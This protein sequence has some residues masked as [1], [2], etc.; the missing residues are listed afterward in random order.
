[1][2]DFACVS[3]TTPTWSNDPRWC[4][5]GIAATEAEHAKLAADL[6]SSAPV[7]G[8]HR[9]YPFM[10]EDRG[11]LGKSALTVVYIFAVLLAPLSHAPGSSS[12]GQPG[13]GGG[14]QLPPGVPSPPPR[15][16]SS[17]G[18]PPSVPDPAPIPTDHCA[19]GYLELRREAV[20]SYFPDALAADDFLAR[21]EVALYGHGFAPENTI[22]VLNLC[23]D[24]ICNT[25]K[26][27]VELLFGQPFNVHGLGGVLTCG[28]TGMGAGLSHCPR[29]GA[30][31]R[32]KYVFFSFPHIAVDAAGHVG[33]VSRAGRPG[34][35]ACGA[36][37]KVLGE[38]RAR[39]DG[40]N[41]KQDEAHDSDDPEYSI[42]KHRLERHI[43]ACGIPVSQLDLDTLTL[44]AEEAIT[45]DLEALIAESVDPARADYAVVTGVQIHNWALDFTDEEPNLEFVQPRSAYVVVGGERVELNIGAVPE[46]TPR[47]LASTM[48]ASAG[49][50]VT[51]ASMRA[52]AAGAD[53]VGGVKSKAAVAADAATEAMYHRFVCPPA[54]SAEEAYL[55][56]RQR[57]VQR[58]FP[59]AEG[60]DDFL[61]RAEV[62]LHGHGFAPDSTIAV[63]NLCRDE[64]CNTLKSKVQ[65]V[66]GAPF[67]VH[68]LGGVL[69]C[70]VTGMGA[71]LSHCP[72]AAPG[73]REKYVFFS[74]PHIAV[75]AAG[76]V[77]EVSRAGCPGSH[78]CGALL[79]VLGELR[80]EATGEPPVCRIEGINAAIEEEAHDVRDP[81]YSILKH[82]LERHLVEAGIP[83][84]KLSLQTLTLLAEEAITQ[85][86]EAL[87]AASVDPAKADY[88]VVT[89]VQIHNWARD[90][91][92]EEPNLEFVQPCAA[93]AVVDGRRVEL[94]LAGSPALTP[95]MFQSLLRNPRGPADCKLPPSRTRGF[96]PPVP[97]DPRSKDNEMRRR[98]AEERYAAWAPAAEPDLAVSSYFEQR[99]ALLSRTFPDALALE[100]FMGRVEL[101][102]DERGFRPDASIAV[103][104][105]CR[106]E[107]CNTLKAKVQTVYGAPFNVHGLGGVLTCGVTGMGAGLSHC[108]RAAPG[109]REKYVFFSFPHIAVDAAGRVGEVS[110]AGCPGSHACGALL[111]VLG[112]L[113]AEATSDKLISSRIEEFHDVRDPEYSI[114]KHR[115]KRHIVKAGIDFAHLRL[116]TLTVLAEE[117]ITQDL[118]ALIAAT[119]DPAK[120]DYAVVT[121]VQ[122]HNWADEFEGEEPHL[123]YVQPGLLYT[124][125]DGQR[126]DLDLHSITALT[127]R[128]I[129]GLA[130]PAAAAAAISTETRSRIPGWA[131]DCAADPRSKAKMTER[132]ERQLM[133]Q[134]YTQ[135]ND[136]QAMRGYFKLRESALHAPFP[137]ALGAD[138]F[139][140]RVEVE[141]C[142]FGFNAANSIAVLNLCRDEIC[143]PLKAKVQAVYGSPFN[144]HGLGGVL[145]CGVTGMGAGLS[146][147][148]RPRAGGRDKYIFFSFPHIA[149]DAA[150]RVGEVSRAGRPGS[151]A[152][153][154][155]LK[156]L[157]E[158]KR[159]SGEGLHIDAVDARDPEYSILKNRLERHVAAVGV[160]CEEL[161]LERLTALAEEAITQDLEA[162]I[163]ATVDPAKADYAVVTGVQIHNW[164]GEFANEEPNLEFVQPRSV[165]VV[166]GGKRQALDLTKVTALTPRMLKS[167]LGTGREATSNRD[168]HAATRPSCVAPPAAAFQAWLAASQE[169]A[170]DKLA[171]AEAL[172]AWRGAVESP[173]AR[174]RARAPA[175]ASVEP[176]SPPPAAP[177]S[178]GGRE[179]DV[180]SIA[181][182]VAE[183]WPAAAPEVKIGEAEAINAKEVAEDEA[184]EEEEEVGEAQVDG[185]APLDSAPP[186]VSTAD[187]PSADITSSDALTTS[188]AAAEVAPGAVA[189]EESGAQTN[190]ANAGD[191]RAPAGTTLL[192]DATARAKALLASEAAKATAAAADKAAEKAV[193]TAAQE[194][195]RAAVE[196]AERLEAAAAAAAETAAAAARQKAMEEAE[197]ARLAAQQAAQLVAEEAA[198]TAAQEA[199]AEA[200]A[201]RVAA[202]RR[203]AKAEEEAAR[204]AAEKRAAEEAAGQK[205][206]GRGGS[207][208][209][210]R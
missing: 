153:G 126:T 208:K 98:Q 74:F 2:I 120:A 45:K 131:D 40:K 1:M 146:H 163:A 134:R 122:V 20:R 119:V 15:N 147:C 162:L 177:S 64:I 79:K 65:A 123:E 68:G 148:P 97:G 32:D 129:H 73:Q 149:V 19:A 165:Y 199:A 189:P 142:R 204:L 164:A 92:D 152:C 170:G 4:T 128:M 184:K 175:P 10:V 197:T 209:E 62:A 157:G 118:E 77:G 83:G 182:V 156:V 136:S 150:G 210:G 191:E 58:C 166:V 13:D 85:D 112:E 71:G 190:A 5:P 106:D 176:A 49:A 43:A 84:S 188:E 12:E 169:A 110:R 7:H 173:C 193:R 37:L 192:A 107:I 94:D 96:V 8:V 100:D 24:E 90:Y 196:E 53:A 93:Y 23:R 50:A 54:G 161:T 155:L 145:T 135:S 140:A 104:N 80:T 81:E 35:H 187:I 117:A 60:V 55:T 16:P 113:R 14:N 86:L 207:G 66:Y 48:A 41:P 174:A 17:D 181:D 105:L 125:V 202:E 114:L 198:R 124:V 82:R 195:A 72:R 111:K 30:G 116:E 63:L 194:A 138:D 186:A 132:Q 130:G 144:V 42:L 29:G 38:L 39:G 139:L 70:G 34:S 31:G 52:I 154:A 115:L 205:G 56:V 75:D 47:M 167:L 88:A 160:R 22:A 206:G 61:A 172:Q 28:V 87:I 158:L 137:G 21:V 101:G 27:K 143:N 51:G 18:D 159:Q 185:G 109:Q 44:L 67:N 168:L 200:E 141:L 108:P 133:Y 102:L 178:P 99:E 89:G 180:V 151:H 46:L 36:L 3:S 95:R 33:E 127:P 121:G 201:A 179:D 6:A 203:A 103:L 59:A 26:A 69:T 25:L 76:H 171:A 11:R 57:V 91:A 78:A 183:P 9:Y